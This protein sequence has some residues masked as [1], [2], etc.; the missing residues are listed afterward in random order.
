MVIGDPCKKNEKTRIFWSFA[1]KTEKTR[2]FWSFA[3]KMIYDLHLRTAEW[4]SHSVFGDCAQSFMRL[5]KVPLKTNFPLI[6]ISMHIWLHHS[7]VGVG[8]GSGT[9]DCSQI[10]EFCASIKS[11][12]GNKN[13][14]DEFKD[15]CCSLFRFFQLTISGDESL[16]KS[17]F[18]QLEN[19]NT[20]ASTRIHFLS[21]T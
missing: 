16:T 13:F 15:T 7:V 19:D 2:I 14:S 17:I 11:A 4:L 21:R 20:A 6:S 3:K 18:D 8:R 5:L 1:K 12:L 10:A 9:R